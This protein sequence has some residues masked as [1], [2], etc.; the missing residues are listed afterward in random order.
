MAL[1]LKNKIDYFLSKKGLKAESNSYILNKILVAFLKEKKNILWK[2]TKRKLSSDFLFFFKKR[3]KVIIENKLKLTL[4]TIISKL[5]FLLKRWVIGRINISKKKD[6]AS[7]YI[8]I[9]KLILSYKKKCS[10]ICIR[11]KPV[12]YFFFPKF[13]YNDQ[14]FSRKIIRIFRSTLQKKYENTYALPF[15]SVTFLEKNKQNLVRIHIISL[16]GFFILSTLGKK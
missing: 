11:K 3:I 15:C 7:M 2:N 13:V 1:K 12:K 14:L 5:N 16:F 4:Y 10:Q 9:F 6:Y 8:H